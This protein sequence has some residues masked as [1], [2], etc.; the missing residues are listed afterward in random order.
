M[1]KVPRVTAQVMVWSTEQTVALCVIAAMSDLEVRQ[2][3]AS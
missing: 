3:H 1:L 2:S